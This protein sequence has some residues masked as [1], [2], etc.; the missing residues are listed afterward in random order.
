[1]IAVAT[2]V[3]YKKIP[4]ADHSHPA[5][6][7]RLTPGEA[8]R[9][10]KEGGWETIK[11]DERTCKAAGYTFCLQ[12]V[13][14]R[15]VALFTHEDRTYAQ[16]I[17]PDKKTKPKPMKED[18]HGRD[19]G[20]SASTREGSK[21]DVALPEVHAPVCDGRPGAKRPVRQ[22]DRTDR[23]KASGVVPPPSPVRKFAGAVQPGMITSPPVVRQEE[24]PAGPSPRRVKGQRRLKKPL[25]LF[26]S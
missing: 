1:M 21:A 10:N 22:G 19:Q 24:E 16:P 25:T 11:V 4:G 20:G 8:H 2:E 17:H 6:H 5:Y 9:Q 13:S 12:W 7:Y 26:D 3:G 15:T 23:P 14:G 18:G